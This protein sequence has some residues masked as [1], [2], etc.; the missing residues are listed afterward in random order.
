MNALCDVIQSTPEYYV[1]TAFRAA[2]RL[3]VFHGVYGAPVSSLRGCPQSHP[4]RRF[5]R[6]FVRT[7]LIFTQMLVL[8]PA[9]SF[10]FCLRLSSFVAPPALS[11]PLDRL[12]KPIHICPS[13]LLSIP[14]PR[15][16]FLLFF[17]VILSSVCFLFV[18]APLPS[19]PLPTFFARFRCE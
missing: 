15:R 5:E 10:L 9:C 14:Y 17:L 19:L 6:F 4:P 11:P 3:E 18:S 8:I 2:R 12:R 13:L 1:I 7:S 16:Q